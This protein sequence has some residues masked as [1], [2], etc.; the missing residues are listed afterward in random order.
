MDAAKRRR[1]WGPLL[2]CV[3][4]W[5]CWVSLVEPVSTVQDSRLDPGTPRL[6]SHRLHSH[7]DVVF[8][9]SEMYESKLSPESL[10]FIEKNTD[11]FLRDSLV[12]TK[13]CIDRYCSTRR[14]RVHAKLMHPMKPRRAAIT[15]WGVFRS[16]HLVMCNLYTHILVP[17]Y[18]NGYVEVDVFYHT[19]RQAS[20][21][22]AR[23]HEYGARLHYESSHLLPQATG[24]VSDPATFWESFP[25]EPFQKW[26]DYWGKADNFTSTRHTLLA[27]NSMH[28]A[29]IL[30]EAEARSYDLVM[31]TR[32]DV[33]LTTELAP[34]DLRRVQGFRNKGLEAW[35]RPSW[36]SW[37]GDNDR[38]A[39][40]TPR[41]MATWGKRLEGAHE[42][43]G[44]HRAL[45][46]ETFVK[47]TMQRYSLLS[48]SRS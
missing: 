22:N 19:Y 41:A 35:M 11:P 1:G 36:Q 46:S 44:H 32:P 6:N 5:L 7:E 8:C 4:L 31:Y 43:V 23:S 9:S 24:I 40:G 27:L 21:A 2:T 30:W 26:G 16:L 15:L 47:W 34:T 13:E 14:G 10:V 18:E 25:F 42:Y 3:L 38:F 28:T 17:F 37:R 29:T 20:L 33:A 39:I 45:G 48:I 12:A